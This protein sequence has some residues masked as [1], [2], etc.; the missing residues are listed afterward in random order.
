[1]SDTVSESTPSAGEAPLQRSSRRSFLGTAAGLTGVALATG[2]WRPATGPNEAAPIRTY[3]A[4][5]FALELDGTAAG[6]LKSVEGGSTYADVINEGNPETFAK[7]HIGSPK[8]ED[9]SLQV[10][11]SMSK[12][13]YDWIDTSWTG[14]PPRKDGAVLA[15][16]FQLKVQS[17]RAFSQALV[18]ETTIPA[19]DGASKDP[20]YLTLRFAVE[21]IQDGTN[22]GK[23]LLP[24][25]KGQKSWLPSNFR[26]K[27]GGLDCTK[28]SK[29]DAFTIK[30]TLARNSDGNLSPTKLEFPNL[31]LTLSS[32]SASSFD[33]WFDDF[34]I[35]GNNSDA[36]EKSGTLEFLSA[37]RSTTIAHM[38]LSNI[39]IYRFGPSPHMSNADTVQ[40]FQA[41]LYCERM[42]FK[43]GAPPVI[44]GG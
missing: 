7:K 35:T 27:L 40:R 15:A 1:M 22:I 33:A 24:D 26:L 42:T 44:K 31:T 8:Y 17:S 30:T 6:F 14:S 34:V 9:F 19:C 18:T 37:D 39:G 4:G 38:G 21:N 11:F 10:G 16:D 12:A 2:A 41:E 3:A 20:G 5:N 13:V 23:T 25:A 43:L 29:I 28:V 36:Y 32:T